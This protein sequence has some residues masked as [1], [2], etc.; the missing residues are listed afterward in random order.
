MI[1][2]INSKP[3]QRQETGQ[4]ATLA[5]TKIKTCSDYFLHGGEKGQAM[6]FLWSGSFI[7]NCSMLLGWP[8]LPACGKAMSRLMFIPF[9]LGSLS[10]QF[11]CNWRP[12][13]VTADMVLPSVLLWPFFCGGI[14]AE[15]TQLGFSCYWNPPCVWD[16]PFAL[17]KGPYSQNSNVSCCGTSY[18][19]LSP[20]SPMLGC[21]HLFCGVQGA[22]GAWSLSH[23]GPSTESTEQ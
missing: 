15:Q 21:W 18:S 14:L 13:S 23:W 3:C 6:A 19:L 4:E 5:S 1:L 7:C 11:H 10:P 22:C 20:C 9:E 12:S 16:P 2:A 8:W 17:M